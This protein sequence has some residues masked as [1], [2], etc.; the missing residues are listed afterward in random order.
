MQTTIDT[1]F[2]NNTFIKPYFIFNWSKKLEP[3]VPYFSYEKPKD[4]T[5]KHSIMIKSLYK[6]ITLY[7]NFT[8]F[9]KK[10]DKTIL[11]YNNIELLKSNLQKGIR[12]QNVKVSVLTARHLLDI[13]ELAFL[14]R[15]S[16][17]TIED[18]EINNQF[19][20]I[21]WLMIA[22][23]NKYKLKTKYYFIV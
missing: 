22:C 2:N 17:I 19:P 6:T 3:E 21:I 9:P 8:E 5:Y 14:R 7:G 4:Y 1:I 23:S 20:I 15:I 10:I 16:I 12:R 13:D 11:K 18:V